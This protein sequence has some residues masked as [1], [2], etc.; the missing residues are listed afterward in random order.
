MSSGKRLAFDSAHSSPLGQNELTVSIPENTVL[1]PLPKSPRF[2]FRSQEKE[3]PKQLSNLQDISLR[4]K[5][6]FQTNIHDLEL[7]VAALT[8]RLAHERMDRDNSLQDVFIHHIVKPLEASI[9]DLQSN[10]P[11][12]INTNPRSA[13]SSWVRL[14]GRLYALD[15][16]MT[17]SRQVDWED[18]LRNKLDDAMAQLEH[19]IIPDSKVEMQ[20]ADKREGSLFCQF[21][22]LVGS[23]ARRFHDERAGLHAAMARTSHQILA[24]E[25]LDQQKGEIWLEKI[26]HV[27]ELLSEERMIRTAQDARILQLIEH[28]GSIMKEALLELVGSDISGAGDEN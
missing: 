8:A 14:E 11:E 3:I 7:R 28:R 24:M 21:E 9:N 27:R 1:T 20:K 23:M 10:S 16:G 18:S 25:D 4:R 12:S 6:E 22:E 19:Q 15:T 17:H 2:V 26:K 13:A 5:D